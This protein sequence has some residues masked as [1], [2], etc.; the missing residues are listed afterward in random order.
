[1]GR[2]RV[3]NRHEIAGRNQTNAGKCKLTTNI[4]I[5]A[6]APSASSN[7]VDCARVAMV[8]SVLSVVMFASCFVALLFSFRVNFVKN[9]LRTF[10]NKKEKYL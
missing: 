4:T 2:M 7:N 1:M 5:N 9:F 8:L 3:V 6:A 10:V